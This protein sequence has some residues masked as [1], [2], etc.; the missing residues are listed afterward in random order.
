MPWVGF[1]PTIPVFERA[2]KFYALDRAAT[3]IGKKC[4]GLQNVLGETDW[5]VLI[6]MTEK[7]WILIKKADSLVVTRNWHTIMSSVW[8][9]VLPAFNFGFSYQKV[10]NVSEN[11]L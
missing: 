9:L 8:N 5:E 10:D 11:L 7:R 3:V 1:E 6:W 4:I 2:K